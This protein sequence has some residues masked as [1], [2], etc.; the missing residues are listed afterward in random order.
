MVNRQN[1]PD[2]GQII[3]LIATATNARQKAMYQKL[4]EK[5]EKQLATEKPST[6]V[7]GK[8]LLEDSN[9]IPTAKGGERL[10]KS[11]KKSTAKKSPNSRSSVEIVV[12]NKAEGS[13]V[14]QSTA[15]TS[16]V[17]AATPTKVEESNQS[18]RETNQAQQKAIFQGIGVI[19]GLVSIDQRER[20]TITVE[21]QKYRLGYAPRSRKRSY[22]TLIDEIKS[23]GTRVKKVSVYPQF[24][25]RQN[26]SNRLNFNLVS[27]EKE[28]E[29]G[30]WFELVPGEFFLSG[31]YQY[32]PMCSFPCITILRNYSDGLAKKV[33]KMGTKNASQLLKPNHLPVDWSDAPISAFKYNPHLEK[34]EQMIRWFVQLKASLV[35][36]EKIFRVISQRGEASQ[37]A[38]SYLKK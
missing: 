21:S 14:P 28:G 2:L 22:Q 7:E 38:P 25:H 23:K 24:D 29:K 10:S 36:Q 31:F 13:T 26:Q 35:S 9:K 30:I 12:N 33:E 17:T 27:V 6:K 11:V 4:L 16:Y 37:K 20:L 18:N 8:E 1:Q 15:R 34:A 3:E 32:I 19:E 5:A